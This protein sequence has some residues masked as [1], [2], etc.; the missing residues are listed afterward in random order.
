MTGK[1]G[2]GATRGEGKTEP[3]TAEMGAEENIAT[4]G[5]ESGRSVTT[6]FLLSRQAAGISNKKE[7]VGSESSFPRLSASIYIGKTGSTI[8]LD[9]AYLR[10]HP[11][12]PPPARKLWRTK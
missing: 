10:H 5:D 1:T 7:D 6:F 3:G 4:P 12:K 9:R 8:N 2:A 11:A